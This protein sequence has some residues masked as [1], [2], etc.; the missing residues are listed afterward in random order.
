MKT[1][2]RGLCFVLLTVGGMAFQSGR[3]LAVEE[4]LPPEVKALIGMEVPAKA[5]GRPGDVPGWISLWGSL[6]MGSETTDGDEF[7][8]E[9]DQKANITILIVERLHKFNKTI[10]D[11]R[12]IPGNLLPYYTEKKNGHTVWK[13]KDRA[14]F[15]DINEGC[16]RSN[17][18]AN[19][20]IIGM[21]R[22]KPGHLCKAAFSQVKKA[23]LLD[24]NNGHLT[25]ISTEGVSCRD[26]ADCED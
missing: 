7:G 17:R 26:P 5:P 14:K 10:L 23:W 9:I 3:A 19:E 18:E 20:I 11:A 21:W 4:P 25:E 6:I 24:R 15:F 2:L 16:S 13:E 1:I 12:V 22:Y 8:F